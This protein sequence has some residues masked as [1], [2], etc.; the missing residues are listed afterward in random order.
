[1]KISF[2]RVYV[3]ILPL[4]KPYT[5]AYKTI[6]DTEIVF[7]E[8]ELE[9]GIIGY[10]AANPFADV[11]GET[12]SVTFQNLKDK[13]TPYLVGQDIRHFNLLIEESYKHFANLP[14]TQAAIDIALHDAFCKYLDISILEFYGQK[15][16]ALPTSITI[17]IKDTQGMMEEASVYRSQG[18]KVLKIKTGL[19]VDQD[20]E[21]VRKLTEKFKKDMWIRVDANQGYSI[22]QLQQFMK[23]TES[24]NIELIEQPLSVKT[25]H[26]L[27]LISKED[28]SKIVADESLLDVR[29]AL[30]L[31]Q[32]PKYY[33]VFNIK[34]MKCG[35]IKGAKAI[36]NIAENAGIHL[37]WGCNDESIVSITA[38]LHAAYSCSNTRF[39]DLDGSFDIVE[40]LFS[41][42]FSVKD[43]YMYPSPKPG[44]GITKN[45]S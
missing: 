28:Q 34:L 14:G 20:I 42:G 26:D 5:I 37:F 41:G 32:D 33:G 22:S 31:S 21:R 43:G 15:I 13:I 18:F 4:T 45:P 19:D 3:Q 25:E 17:G 9:N 40:T 6:T 36:A 38:A 16:K 11:V 10:G 23:E 2:I 8:I 44:L 30:K 12:P 27:V 35:G 1:M 7:L 39:L 29:T 24:L